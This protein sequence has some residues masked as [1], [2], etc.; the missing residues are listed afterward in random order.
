MERNSILL[1]EKERISIKRMM[2]RINNSNTEIH[3]GKKVSQITT[4]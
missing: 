4:N 1:V 3:M 2:R